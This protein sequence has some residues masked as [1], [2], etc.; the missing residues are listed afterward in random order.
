VIICAGS[1]APLL[2]TTSVNGLDGT[3]NPS[4]VDNQS[5]ATYT[6]TPAAAPEQC[7]RPVKLVVVV[8]P[9]LTPLFSFGTTL[10]V[11]AGS[12]APQLPETSSNGIKGTWSPAII[13]NQASGTYTFTTDPGQCA[14]ASAKLTVTVVQIPSVNESAD[15]IVFDGATI[16]SNIFAG[17]PADA[18]FNWVNSNPSIGLPA[19]GNGNIPSFNATNLSDAQITGTITVTPVNNG[20]AGDD[21]TYAITVKPLNKDIFVPNAF[22]PNGDG[23]NDILFVYGNYIDELEM[24]IFNQWGEQIELLNSTSRGWNGMYK[25]KAQPVGVYVYTLKAVLQGGRKV[26]MKGSIT[27]LR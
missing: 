16:P 8:K 4:A 10:N 24:R 13:N 14:T 18:N 9:I 27:L 2:P 12:I 21:K 3:W 5:T 25:G 1:T 17:T 6:F 20:C 11:C 7:V 23:K 19:N 22:S 15:T 26:N